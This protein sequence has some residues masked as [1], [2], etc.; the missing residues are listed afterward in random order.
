MARKI[1]RN[2]PLGGR[3]PEDGPGDLRRPAISR[4]ALQLCGQVARTLEGVLAGELD[5]DVLRNLL[6]VS[7]VPAPDESRLLVTVG[8]CAPGL[9]FDP[10]QVMAHLSAASVRLRAEVAA[11]ITRRRAPTLIFQV[12]GPGPEPE[13]VEST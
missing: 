9:P 4:K 5:D 7:V 13:A 12:A 2:R 1:P 6:V 10:L 8:P 3:R 11:D